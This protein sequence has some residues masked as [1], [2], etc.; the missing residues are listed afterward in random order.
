MH[1]MINKKQK[2]IMKGIKKNFK[3]MHEVFRNFSEAE[4]KKK[5]KDDQIA[6]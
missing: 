5:R 4:K 3:N 1:E 6:T 2:D